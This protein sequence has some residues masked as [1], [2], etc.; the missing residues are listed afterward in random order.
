MFTDSYGEQSCTAGRVVVHHRAE[1]LSHRPDQGRHSRRARR[2]AGRRPR[3]SRN[4]SRTRATP[5]ASSARTTSATST[6]SCPPCTASTSSSATSTTSTPRKSRR[7]TTIRRRRISPSSA[8]ASARAACCIAGR[9]TRTM[10]PSSRAGAVSASREI[11][12]TGPLDQEA[13]GDL[14]RRIRRRR[15]GLHQPPERCRQAVLRLA[16]HHAHAPASPTPSRRASA[17]PAA[18][19]RPITTP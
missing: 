12:D 4:S 1:R 14:R 6:S 10:P 3:R 13:H 15:Q 18:G 5:P 8:S 19:S 2:P 11:E 17:R 9:P 7:C 16:Q